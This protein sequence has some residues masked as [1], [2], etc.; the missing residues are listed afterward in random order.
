MVQRLF[1]SPINRGSNYLGGGPALLLLGRSRFNHGFL[2]TSGPILSCQP[3]DAGHDE[4]QFRIWVVWALTL[5][6]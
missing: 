3:V 5:M 4:S 6:V 1:I 2:S